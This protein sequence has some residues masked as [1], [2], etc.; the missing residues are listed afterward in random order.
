[1][2]RDRACA[3]AT[4]ARRRPRLRPRQRRRRRRSARSVASRRPST[5]PS[6]S[7]RSRSSRSRSRRNPTHSRLK[8]KG[9]PRPAL[10][11]IRTSGSVRMTGAVSS[12][13]RAHQPGS[14]CSRTRWLGCW[15]TSR[16]PASRSRGKA[17]P[18]KPDR[19]RQPRRDSR[20]RRRMTRRCSTRR[21]RL[22]P[23]A[24]AARSRGSVRRMERERRRRAAHRRS[25][26]STR[27]T[28]CQTRAMGRRESRASP[29]R[30]R[31]TQER[32]GANDRKKCRLYVFR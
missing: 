2:T 17:T 20:Q 30:R 6:R 1:M 21:D 18:L 29:S 23:C 19:D 9:L 5:T 14:R 31:R 10:L 8:A 11:S 24:T 27:R 7:S 12:A 4:G 3:A 28:C 32:P 16:S 13:T 22:C 25:A 26:R 15:T